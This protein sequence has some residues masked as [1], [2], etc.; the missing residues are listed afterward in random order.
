MQIGMITVFCIK[1]IKIRFICTAQDS[2]QPDASAFISAGASGFRF[3]Y[4]IIV[5]PTVHI[6]NIADNLYISEL[7]IKY[8]RSAVSGCF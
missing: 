6:Y 3:S 1:Q 8:L 4:R 5:V 2:G 7:N